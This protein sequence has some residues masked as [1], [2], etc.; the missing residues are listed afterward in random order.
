MNAAEK[1]TWAKSF[2]QRAQ[3]R[4]TEPR[5]RILRFLS[6]HHLPASIDMIM[7]SEHFAA[8]C[9]E[10]TIYRTLML[11]REIDLVRQ[12]NLP[13][14]PSYFVL[15]A[16]GQ[17]SDFLV[18]RRCGRVQELQ[19]PKSLLQLEQDVAAKSGFVAIHHELELYGICPACQMSGHDPTPTK[20]ASLKPT[21]SRPTG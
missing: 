17:V 16:P 15:N 8:D 11:F 5:E 18:C 3:L 7:Q 10:T 12:I 6:E 14:K 4:V 2:C 20:L 19:T 9:A 1:L 21:L 13:A